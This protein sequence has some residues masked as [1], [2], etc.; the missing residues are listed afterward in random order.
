MKSAP[1]SRPDL[2]GRHRFLLRLEK[3]SRGRYALVFAVALFVLLTG[4]FL[5]SRLSV[6]SDILA[7]I[8]A[9]NR[10]V[11]NFKDAVTDFGS[12]SY[13][14]MLLD[15][16][17]NAGPDELEDFADVLAEDLLAL[18]GLVELV[19]HRLDPG[20]DFLD[21]FYDNALLYLHP[22]RLADL[23]AKLESD[24]ILN[25]IRQNRL[26]LS[27]PTATFTQELMVNDPLNLMPLLFRPSGS[28]GNLRVDLTDGYYLSRD[29]QSLILLIKPTGPWQDLDFDVRL[30]EAVREV[31]HAARERLER[32]AREVGDDPADIEVRYTGRYA[33]AVD[34]AGLV[35]QDIRFNL[36]FSLFAVSAL[37][38]LCYRRFA[39]LLYSSVPLLVGQAMTFGLAFFLLPWVSGSRGLN[40]ASSAFTA[41][42]M[43]LG[44]DFVIV[45]Y[46]RYVEERRLGRTLAQATELMVGETGLGVFT[47]A[48]TSAGTF[49][50]MCISEFRGL[51]DL[52]FLIGSGIL[53]CAAA[54]V[55][56]VPAMIKWNEGVR[57][58]KV[59]S[60]KKLHVQSFL[61][62]HLMPFSARYRYVVIPAVILL[63][64]ASAY[65]SVSGFLIPGQPTLEFD[66]TVQ[67]LRSERSAAYSVQREMAENFGASL[68]YMMA[69]VDAPTEGEA[70]G[71]TEAIERRLQ[72]YLEDGTVASYNSILSYLPPLA[73]QQRILEA[74]DAGKD[75]PFDTARIRD[76]FLRGLDANGFQV[77][78]FQ[79]F[80]DRM[81]R[82]LS[83]ERPIGLADLERHGLQSLIER[84]VRHR[85]DGVRI[86]TYLSMSDPRWKREPPPGLVE[87]LTAGDEGIVITGTNVVS[88]EFRRIFSREAPRAL[89]LGLGVVFV[90]LLVDFRSLKLTCIAL[91]QLVCGV[92]LMLG[93]MKVTDIHLNYVNAFVATMILGVGID[94]SIH[95]VHRMS[96]TGGA[97]DSGL[98]ETGKAVVIAALTN[99]AAFGTLTLGNYPALRS[100]GQVALIGSLTCLFTAL[101]LVPAIMARR[102]Q[103]S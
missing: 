4:A 86:V 56:L 62:E 83:P 31:E 69:I 74:R 76:T 81:Q 58:R 24:A 6:D 95:L 14:V 27:S 89:L 49:Y 10:H 3:F 51:R 98:L 99:I 7:L 94:Y 18:E 70:I 32:E 39:A 88:R 80:L 12:I 96:L 79:A 91:G 87:D 55:F 1:S 50:A 48:I 17:E 63:T 59:E 37:Y 90:L 8:P 54:I 42:L 45:M 43:G 52:G 46:A 20:A 71:L 64:L 75:G 92:I 29:G 13:L 30:M 11:D 65:V 22:D 82:F 15:A 100:F 34:E 23:E 40:A 73:Q 97:V 72:P 66:D 61:V 33:I 19:E 21:L 77:E 53:L 44:T 103:V 25:Q 41:L 28:L 16:G 78:P 68:S 57:K 93:L 5:G 101:T 35:R 36:L 2:G 102:G 9:G 67:V 84:Y 85:T 60:I 47:G 26:S 38:W